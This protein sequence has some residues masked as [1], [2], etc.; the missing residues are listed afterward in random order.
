MKSEKCMHFL[1]VNNCLSTLQMVVS[2]YK[3]EDDDDLEALRLAA[4]QTIRPRVLPKMP[5]AYHR[6]FDKVLL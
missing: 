3:M 1:F 6:Q 2:H 5:Q 4:L